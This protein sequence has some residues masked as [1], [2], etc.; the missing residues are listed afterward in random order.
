[1]TGAQIK[2]MRDYLANPAGGYNWDALDGYE[3]DEKNSLS[4]TPDLQDKVRQAI[5]Q[6]HVDDEDFNGVSYPILQFAS[7]KTCFR[8]SR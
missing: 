8:T 3:G 2:N 5:E 1:M 7:T 4:R 6:G